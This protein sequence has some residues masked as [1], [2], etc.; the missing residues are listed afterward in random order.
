M[1]S[2]RK[3]SSRRNST[4]EKGIDDQMSL[5]LHICCQVQ[6]M[7][8]VILLKEESQKK[9]IMI[10]LKKIQEDNTT[11]QSVALGIVIA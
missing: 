6:V 3:T 1:S 5:M 9:T 7:K 11:C 8:M 10:P 4:K 2:G